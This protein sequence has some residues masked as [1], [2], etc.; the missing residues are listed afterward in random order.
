MG[1]VVALRAKQMERERETKQLAAVNVVRGAH[2]ASTVTNMEH[3]GVLI[4]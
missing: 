1:L 3:P 4:Q 2:A